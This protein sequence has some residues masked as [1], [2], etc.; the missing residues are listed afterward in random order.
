MPRTM[1]CL[2]AV[3]QIGAPPSP[4]VAANLLTPLTEYV[5]R[6]R[7][8][9]PDLA[10]LAWELAQILPGDARTTERALRSRPVRG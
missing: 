6:Y 3:I 2:Y 1:S 5:F 7:V 10:R 4:E 8:A 9:D